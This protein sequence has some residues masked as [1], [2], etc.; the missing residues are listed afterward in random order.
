[1]SLTVPTPA[2]VSAAQIKFQLLTL[3]SQIA[4]QVPRLAKVLA[5]PDVVTALGTTDAATCQAIVTA[6]Q[7]VAP[8]AS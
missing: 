4:A 3:Q 6:L 5:E 7:A 8:L 2:Q 1:M